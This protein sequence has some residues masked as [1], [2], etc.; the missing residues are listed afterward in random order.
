MES[1]NWKT[2]G[3]HSVW[4]G[5]QPLSKKTILVSNYNENADISKAVV[6]KSKQKQK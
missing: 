1:E 5:N 6:H 3:F 2:A 4:Y